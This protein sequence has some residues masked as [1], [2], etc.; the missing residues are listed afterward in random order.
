MVESHWVPGHS[1]SAVAPGHLKWNHL[2]PATRRVCTVF[3]HPMTCRVAHLFRQTSQQHE[4][5]GIC[6]DSP[7]KV[8]PPEFHAQFPHLKC[9]IYAWREEGIVAQAAITKFRRLSALNHA[10]VR[11]HNSR[12]WKSEFRV[13]ECSSSGEGLFLGLQLATFSLCP[14]M[15]E[16]ERECK[17]SDAFSY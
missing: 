2:T 8:A 16:R 1:S 17:L 13:P 10:N 15:A 11:S 6:H 14:H 5:W 9:I 4:K 12:G 3:I 7:Q